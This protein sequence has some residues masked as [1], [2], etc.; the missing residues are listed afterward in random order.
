MKLYFFVIFRKKIQGFTLFL[1]SERNGIKNCVLGKNEFGKGKS[2]TREKLKR[3]Q[4]SKKKREIR[5]KRKIN[6]HDDHEEID[7]L[8]LQINKNLLTQ[9]QLIEIFTFIYL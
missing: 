3:I 9:A 6:H 8:C 1:S 7:P 5:Q 2:L 4:R